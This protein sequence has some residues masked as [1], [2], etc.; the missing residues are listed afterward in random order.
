LVM[1]LVRHFQ[2]QGLQPGVVSR[3]YGRADRDSLEV[4]ADTPV[5]ASG[6]EPA[7]IQRSTGAPV[8]VAAR[9]ADALRALLAAYP[10]TDVVVCDDGLQH[11]ALQRDIEIAVFDDRGVGNGWL[12][13]A[14]PLREPWPAR[15][16]L[17]IDLVLHTGQQ[18]AFD[19][20]TSSRQLATHAVA[21]DGRHIAL[22]ELRGQPLVA[23]AGI[24]SPEAFFS[25]LRARGL[26]LEKTLA[27]PDHHDFKPD[28]LSAC[29]GRTVLCTEKDAIKLFALPTLA[30]L[31]VLAVPL[32]F[33]PE[34]AFFTALD[35]LLAPL[36][37]PLPS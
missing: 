32:E 5:Q 23:L 19:G 4:K 9:R 10:A 28:E 17:G 12:L 13:P 35:A 34:P 29:A 20:F 25:M 30:G 3:G 2:A 15:Q 26:T 24:A 16:R 37:S 8:F 6:D 7:L 27:L 11:Y 21:A 31:E 22:T 14:G 33:S 18:P 36:I 1:A